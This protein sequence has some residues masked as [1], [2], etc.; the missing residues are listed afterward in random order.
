[1]RRLSSIHFGLL[2][3]TTSPEM[4]N[5][6]FVKESPHFSS[7]SKKSEMREGFHPQTVIYPS[8]SR[9]ARCSAG[10]RR[11]F[12]FLAA[13]GKG[14]A[15]PSKPGM[16]RIMLVSHWLNPTKPTPDEGVAHALGNRDAVDRATQER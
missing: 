5:A 12:P 4:V 15:S 6:R 10:Q 13:R 8:M 9:R 16:M 14:F 1:M 2:Q 3:D 7:I 11:T